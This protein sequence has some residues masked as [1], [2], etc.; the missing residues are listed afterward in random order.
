MTQNAYTV[1]FTRSGVRERV[2]YE[3]RG[4]TDGH[5]RIEEY[6]NGCRWITSGREPVSDVV[7]DGA[8][9]VA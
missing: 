5:V 8:R 2:R 6:Y 4:G 1:E 3:P 9:V 7:V